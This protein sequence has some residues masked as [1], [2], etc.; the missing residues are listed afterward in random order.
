MLVIDPM[1]DEYYKA[2][3]WDVKTGLQTRKKL[4]EL[5]LEHVADELEKVNAIK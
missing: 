4:A 1:L 3:E 5:G 2:R